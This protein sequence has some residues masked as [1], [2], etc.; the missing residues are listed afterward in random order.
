M[1]VA[2]ALL[3][4]CWGNLCPLRE[5]G[6][7]GGTT[8]GD[9]D[10]CRHLPRRRKLCPRP[11]GDQETHADRPMG[12]I[13]VW[14]PSLRAPHPWGPTGGAVPRDL[15]C[16]LSP[17]TTLPPLRPRPA[18]GLSPQRPLFEGPRAPPP[19][20]GGGRVQHGAPVSSPPFSFSGTSFPATGV[21]RNVGLSLGRPTHP[22]PL[23]F[24]SVMH[25]TFGN[26]IR[27][28]RE[29]KLTARAF[30]CLMP[31]GRGRGSALGCS[32][33]MKNRTPLISFQKQMGS[34]CQPVGH[35]LTCACDGFLQPPPFHPFFQPSATSR[36]S[37]LYVCSSTGALA[38]HGRA[39]P[40]PRH[41]PNPHPPIWRASHRVPLGLGRSGPNPT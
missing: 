29:C 41:G 37:S 26:K 1:P 18:P 6:S 5:R 25:F 40:T 2:R 39:S 15:A 16:P 30:F 33:L 7:R 23:Y 10:K 11:Q 9:C 38:P 22:S 21:R 32:R 3:S 13:S 34:H 27:V 14:T 28:T 12:S 24:A 19:V 20:G 17:I 31:R 8:S 35:V 4:A 36:P